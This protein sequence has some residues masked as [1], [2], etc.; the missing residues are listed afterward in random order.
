MQYSKFFQ[1]QHNQIM[2]KISQYIDIHPTPITLGRWT[3]EKCSDKIDTKI[4]MA[5]E[6]HCGPCGNYRL[7][8]HTEK[9][10]KNTHNSCSD[11]YFAMIWEDEDIKK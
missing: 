2:R 8:K 7:D 10:K 3:V 9:T 6:D 5:N 11:D 1:I 4:E